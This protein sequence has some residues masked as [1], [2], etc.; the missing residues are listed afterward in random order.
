MS[1]KISA[2]GDSILK[3]VVFEKGKYKISENNFANLCGKDLGVKIENKAKFGSTISVG[4]KSIE[5]NL[6][7]IKNSDSK[8]VLMEFGGNDCDYDWKSISERPTEIHKPKSE[9]EDFVERYTRLINEIK[10][11]NKIP[12]LLSLPPIDAEK[13]F[14]KISEGLNGDNIL[15]WMN[16]N[17]QHISNWH[18]RYNIE[19]FKLA[20]NNN[21]PIIDITSKFLEIKDYSKLL[22]DDGIHPNEDGH[23][24]IADAINEHI[25]KKGIIINM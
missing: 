12:V 18:E 9:V 8:Y 13:Y 25:K 21:I 24:L 23:K 10:S 5:K 11:M 4:E 7:I 16:G 20:M 19:V 15:I 1:K 6:D 17:K 2:F 22:C 14:K 3:G